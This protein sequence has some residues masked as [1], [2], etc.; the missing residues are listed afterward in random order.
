MRIVELGF[1]SIFCLSLMLL[2][3]RLRF[4]RR[5]DV[6]HVSGR[7]CISLLPHLFDQFDSD[8]VIQHALCTL[9]SAEHIDRL[10]VRAGRR[11]CAFEQG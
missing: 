9:H 1:V 10:V 5:D 3:S 2:H 6:I 11:L 8:G 4:I 7:C